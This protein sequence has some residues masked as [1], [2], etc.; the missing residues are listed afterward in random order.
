MG[1][2]LAQSWFYAIKFDLPNLKYI[3]DSYQVGKDQKV[4]TI[5]RSI[6]K[7][8]FLNLQQ[9]LYELHG[10]QLDFI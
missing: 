3:T 9:E 6:K 8:R 4:K 1:N 2:P 7:S 5:T 10:M